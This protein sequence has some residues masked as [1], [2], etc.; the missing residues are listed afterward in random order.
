[1][2]A[3]P[4]SP[5]DHDQ[6]TQPAAVGVVAGGAAHDGDDLLNLGWVGRVVESAGITGPEK[7]MKTLYIEGLSV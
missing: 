2:D 7:E 1:V 4:G 5:Q 3:Q 6:A